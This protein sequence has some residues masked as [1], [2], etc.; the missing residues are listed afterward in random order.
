M[1]RIGDRVGKKLVVE[2]GLFIFQK[3]VLFALFVDILG[4]AKEHCWRLLL[5]DRFEE[6]RLS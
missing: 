1:C 6:V 5:K 3:S 4:V 2:L